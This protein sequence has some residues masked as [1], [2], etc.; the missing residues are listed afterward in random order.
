M[1]T[2][3]PGRGQPPCCHRWPHHGPHQGRQTGPPADDWRRGHSDFREPQLSRNLELVRL[4]RA[5]GS[6]HGRSP[7]EVAVAWVLRDAAVTGAIVGARRPAQV[8]GLSGAAEFRLS[9]RELAEI[10]GF[11]TQVAA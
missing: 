4:L 8:R 1:L 5:I 6:R 7:G 10:E 9:A 2:V 11:V 3:C